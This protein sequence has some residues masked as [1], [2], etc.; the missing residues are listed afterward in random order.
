MIKDIGL[1]MP[2]FAIYNTLFP[3]KKALDTCIQTLITDFAGFCI[4]TVIYFQRS[5]F[6]ELYQASVSFQT[7]ADEPPDPVLRFFSWFSLEKKFKMTRANV[8]RHLNHFDA[9]RKLVVDEDLI[10]TTRSIEDGQKKME[11]MMPSIAFSI[12]AKE[13]QRFYSVPFHQNP[14]FDVRWDNLDLLHQNLQ[15]IA[16][17]NT[18]MRQRSCLIHG[19]AGVGKTQLAIEYTYMHRAEYDYIIWFCAETDLELAKAM[20]NLA[21]HLQL[22]SEDKSRSRAS[23]EATK[24]W[25][26]QTGR[27]PTTRIRA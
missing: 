12:S 22:R 13:P 1:L 9:Q 21:S 20:G 16:S 5:S 27:F 7:V 8:V 26:E 25:L 14:R 19:G 18:A 6:S 15:R 4:D 24:L 23:L 10:R 3:G 11:A 2:Q 17:N